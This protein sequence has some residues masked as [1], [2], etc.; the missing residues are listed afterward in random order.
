MLVRTARCS[1]SSSRALVSYDGDGRPERLVGINIDVTERKRAEAILKESEIVLADALAAGQVIAFEWDARTGQS[2][3]SD[4]A[5]HV[6]GDEQGGTANSR[7]NDFLRRVHPDD[8]ER[9]RSQIRKLCAENPS[10]A[11]SF[12]FCGPD[13]HQLWLEETARGEFDATGRLL[14]IKGLTRDT[15]ERKKAEMALAERN[16]QLSLAGKAA[17]V[18]SFAFDAGSERVRI[19]P[20]YAAIHGFPDGTAEIAR[21][22]WQAS[23]HPDD[24]VRLEGL[25]SSAFRTRLN[26]YS[27]DY[28]IV[29][30]GGEVR[31]IDARILVSYDSDG[32]P[33]R[34]VGVNIDITERKRAEEHQR[35]LNAELDHRVKNVLATVSAVISQTQETS[36]S[37]ADFVA[38]LDG[39]VRSLAST[40]ELLSHAHWRGVSLA[41][42]AQRK[43]APYVAGNAE[44]A[45]PAV[46][47]KAE[48]A[49][50]VAMVLHELTTNAAKYGAFSNR[51]GRVLLKWWWLQNGSHG[52]LAIEWQEI[53]GPPVLA[54]RQSGYGMSII[55]EL[56]PYELSGT[57][58]LDFASD[59]VRCR[60]N[61]PADWISRGGRLNDDSKELDS[62]TTPPH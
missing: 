39:R 14:R 21:S 51:C 30:S 24:L 34:V 9:F 28:R 31:W 35:A 58:D 2:R 42:I 3:R 56:I 8:Q 15:T 46:T 19:S 47:L 60:L 55:R 50:A 59:G 16:M 6:V 29:R 12:R 11:L 5:N 32:R 25:R 36:S 41:E 45:G 10:Y 23:V 20:G 52:P 26:Q 4:N 27:V 54:P 22:E 61:I 37:H 43:L 57:A 33:Q 18:G 48:A 38:G 17:L 7:R 53:G 49:Q 40:H 1:G 44:I 62:A 13:G